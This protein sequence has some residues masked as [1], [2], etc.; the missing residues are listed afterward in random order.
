[1]STHKL[2]NV[3]IADFKEFLI[4]VG[5]QYQSIESGHEK[6]SRQDL[7]RPIIFQTHKDPIPEFIIKANLRTLNL[8]KQE[9][10]NILFDVK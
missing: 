10:F 4:K 5:C 7:L 6:W 8:S 3:S 2:S 9:F 1:M